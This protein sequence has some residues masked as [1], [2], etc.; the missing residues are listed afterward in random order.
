MKKWMFV[1]PLVAMP[2]LMGQSAPAGCNVDPNIATPNQIVIGVNAYNAAVGTGTAYLHLPICGKAPCRTQALS[3]SVY[4][5][6]KSGRAAR[7]QL[8]VDLQNNQTA[9]VTLIQSLQAAY[10]VLSTIPQQ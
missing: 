10:A 8:L 2:L 7:D 6:L 5:A 1:L 9:P 3:E 4:T